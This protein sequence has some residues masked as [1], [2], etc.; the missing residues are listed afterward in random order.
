MIQS[1]DEVG[2]ELQSEPICDL[3]VFM[4]AEIQVEVA[5]R[6]QSSE[7]RCA[8][9]EARRRL[10]NISVVDEPLTANPHATDYRCSICDGRQGDAVRPSS[11]TEG[12]GVI[13]TKSR[14]WPASTP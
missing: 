9:S 11:T 12:T 10:N 4:N 13:R 1:V 5:R 6:A 3:E 14:Q 7:L 2:A 8:I